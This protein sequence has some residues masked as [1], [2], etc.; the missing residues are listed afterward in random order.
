MTLLEMLEADRVKMLPQV[1]D[2]CD[3][4]DSALYENFKFPKA[5]KQKRK[6]VDDRMF[7]V[8]FHK[9]N[10]EMVPEID[11]ERID[12]LY[13]IK[14]YR[15]QI[16][17]GGEIQFDV[18]TDRQHLAQLEFTAFLANDLG[19]TLLQEEECC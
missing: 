12:R 3:D 8:Q 11:K 15:K 4:V 9:E 10:G 14:Q 17:S 1:R 18:N 7:P 5:R 13:T 16:E 19:I 6:Q 2:L